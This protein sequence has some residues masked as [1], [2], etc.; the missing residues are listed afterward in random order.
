MISAAQNFISILSRTSN[1]G[2]KLNDLFDID[3]QLI[4][5]KED[6]KYQVGMRS[7]HPSN[8]SKLFSACY[9]Y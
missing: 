2:K 3:M 7:K 9:Y 4:S 6:G 1:W 5:V 8:Y